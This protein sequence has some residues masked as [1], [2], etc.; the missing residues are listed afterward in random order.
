MLLDKLE[1]G[2]LLFQT[3]Q[4][5]LAAEPASV[6]QR[7][8]L[9]WTF[10]NFR[11]LSLP[12][13]NVR[14]TAMV[15]DLFR[16]RAE[17]LP[18]KYDPWRVIGVVEDF[19]PPAP[20]MDAPVASSIDADVAMERPGEMT[21]QPVLTSVGPVESAVAARIEMTPVGESALSAAREQQTEEFVT[22]RAEV[23]T[24][25]GAENLF[26]PQA[27]RRGLSA[28]RSAWV[29]V[30]SFRPTWPQL[31]SFQFAWPKLPEFRPAWSKVRWRR[32][33]PALGA[34]CVCGALAGAWHWMQAAPS[35][36][37]HS[38]SGAQ[39]VNL[40]AAQ[41]LHPAEAV[42]ISESTESAAG[43]FPTAVPT[44]VA[45]TQATTQ[46]LATPES[47]VDPASVELAS[48]VAPVAESK[49]RVRVHEAA[50]L[51]APL[52]VQDDAIQATRPPL[53]FVYP[54]YTEIQARG[55]VALTAGVDPGG[56]VR[57]VRIVSG[58]Q[59]L[60]AAAV[61]AVRQW[62]YRPYLKD[63]QSVATETNIVISF[64]SED[65]ISMTF[66]PAIPVKR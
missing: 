2:F 22:V 39:Q 66:P 43:H 52:P 28:F 10:R 41:N 9:V 33:T 50:R 53:H 49:Q 19:V 65:A 56:N 34:I 51:K 60:A 4:G 3:P 31:P 59:A 44:P 48:A 45:T 55:V 16:H 58:N 12:L 54:I 21:A 38:E 25:P 62:R 20:M 24:A 42:A 7:L 63:G 11:Q 36:Q 17:V 64:F 46:P 47:A 61:R 8:Y 13:L 23:G 18:H 27:D 5:L 30:V 1:S 35:S 40:T 29:K 37:A 57:S 6:W 14:Q 15:N 32:V 26:T